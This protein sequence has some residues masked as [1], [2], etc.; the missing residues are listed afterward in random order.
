MIDV[1]EAGFQLEVSASALKRIKYL[2]TRQADANY[3]RISVESGGCSGLQYKYEFVSLSQ[4]DDACIKKED[5]V[6]LIDSISQKFLHLS[7]LDYIEEL[8]NAYF[9]IRNPK[10]TAKCGCGNSF[11]V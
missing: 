6:L 2:K 10:A 5:V 3:L 8:G 11:T 7:A 4:S 9:E 1:E